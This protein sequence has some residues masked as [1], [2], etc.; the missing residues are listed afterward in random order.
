MSNDSRNNDDRTR[1]SV[2]ELPYCRVTSLKASDIMGMKIALQTKSAGK[3]G[4]GIV[5][6]RTPN[7][8]WVSARDAY[9]IVQALAAKPLT[10]STTYSDKF[11]SVSL[12]WG[13]QAVHHV[14]VG[15]APDWFEPVMEYHRN[16]LMDMPNRDYRIVMPYMVVVGKSSLSIAQLALG[17]IGVGLNEGEELDQRSVRIL[18]PDMDLWLETDEALEAVKALTEAQPR[19]VA[20][21]VK[22][23]FVLTWGGEVI[24][25]PDLES[26]EFDWLEPIAAYFSTNGHKA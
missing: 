19:L 2:L 4:D 25:T 6:L 22:K 18:T 15:K 13:V 7:E 16:N 8:I 23:K 5:C 11:N 14:R 3:L 24:L 10:I 26:E 9:R 17:M 21:F 20:D 1:P 12:S